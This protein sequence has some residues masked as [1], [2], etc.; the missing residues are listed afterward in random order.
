MFNPQT[1]ELKL[2]DWGLADF[3]KPHT[4]YTKVGTLHYKAPE[5][6][7]NITV[8]DYSIDIWSLGCVMGSLILKKTVMFDGKTQDVW[9]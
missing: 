6:L 5:M 7:L 2:I 9:D 3:Y 1:Q 4:V 8:Y